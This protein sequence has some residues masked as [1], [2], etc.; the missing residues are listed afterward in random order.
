MRA[1]ALTAFDNGNNNPMEYWNSE[2]SHVDVSDYPG[3]VNGVFV[4]GISS[5]DYYEMLYVRDAAA[6]VPVPSPLA[7]LGLGVVAM[8][9]K[10]RRA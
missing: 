6:Q 2:F 7:L 1:R 4:A 3:Q 8:F 10:K 9:F 5:T